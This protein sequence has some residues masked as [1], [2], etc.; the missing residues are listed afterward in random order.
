MTTIT[1]GRETIRNQGDGC[2][3]RSVV[4]WRA[5]RHRV[6]RLPEVRQCF[7]SF[8]EQGWPRPATPPPVHGVRVVAA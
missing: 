7:S 3:I 4:L 8:R 1:M 2:M 5:E 6:S